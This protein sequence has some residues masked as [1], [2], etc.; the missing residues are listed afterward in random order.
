MCSCQF[1]HVSQNKTVSFLA[2]G[3]RFV[4]H[5]KNGLP[6]SVVNTPIYYMASSVS[7]QD[8]P[9]WVLWLATQV[10]KIELS[11][12]LDT[13][14]CILQEK[15]PQKPYNKCIIDQACLVKMTGFWLCSFLASLWTST[16]SRSI[17][18][19]KKDLANIQPSSPHTWSIFII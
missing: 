16:S 15:F 11:C 7:G 4:R 2:N 9:N 13:T 18:T 3:N 19:Q 12:L 14:C 1:C 10:G 6:V 17:N 5:W 8:E